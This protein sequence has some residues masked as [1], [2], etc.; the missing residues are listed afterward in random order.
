MVL[1]AM[2][3]FKFGVGSDVYCTKWTLNTCVNTG[4]ETKSLWPSY[5]MMMK[6]FSSFDLEGRKDCLH[7]KLKIY[8]MHM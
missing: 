1:G 3:D 2:G 4:F 7:H 8:F 6:E 5:I